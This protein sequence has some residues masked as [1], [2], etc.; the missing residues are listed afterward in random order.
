MNEPIIESRRLLAQTR[1]FR[2]EQ[3][4]LVFG[5][6]SRR[7]FERVAGNNESVLIVPLLDDQTILLIREYAAGTERYELGLPKGIIESGEDRFAAAQREIQEEVGYGAHDLR[8][9][10]TVTVAPGY[11]Q[12]RTHLIL[13]RELYPQ[14]QAGDEPEPIEVVPWPL[15]RLDALL[16]REDFS[17]A[18]S[19]AALFLA[20]QALR[21]Q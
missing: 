12:H 9:L 3:L 6:G 7:C 14:R 8:H 15:D 10:S 21:G 13:A 1:I 4:E 5:N 19:I 11:I 18:R 16:Q 2:I 20:R 17:E